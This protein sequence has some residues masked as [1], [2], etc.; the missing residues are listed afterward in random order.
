MIPSSIARAERRGRRWVPDTITGTLCSF[1][2][3]MHCSAPSPPQITGFRPRR[4]AQSTALSMLPGEFA[5]SI[6]G[7]R[8]RT[9]STMFWNR[10]S[11]GVPLGSASRASAQAF[12]W[13]K[14][15]SISFS[16]FAA[17]RF[18][19][20]TLLSIHG[21]VIGS[22][23]GHCTTSPARGDTVWSSLV[24]PSRRITLAWPLTTPP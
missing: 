7:S 8:P 5:V 9:T 2:R 22:A 16:C 20:S 21:E 10:R 4:V 19:S 18:W 6:T 24:Q 17:S 11:P 14:N 23:T 13:S 12:A 3:A 1:S 15:R